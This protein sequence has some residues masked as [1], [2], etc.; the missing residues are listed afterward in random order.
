[1]DVDP[2][3]RVV[4]R[5]SVKNTLQRLSAVRKAV[6]KRVGRAFEH[7][8]QA[9]GALRQVL[10]DLGSCPFDIRVINA[11]ADDPW[12]FRIRTQKGPRIGCP[13]RYRLD[14]DTVGGTRNQGVLDRFSR[15]CPGYQRKPA[16]T[17]GISFFCVFV[18][19][20]DAHRMYSAAGHA[21]PSIAATLGLDASYRNA[22][23]VL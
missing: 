13:L 18:Q 21:A 8:A 17:L 20:S 4:E 11:L 7:Q 1:M 5:Y 9:G 6:T 19:G 14:A 16:L 15:K 2:Q 12:L 10:G 3:M 23:N 22:A